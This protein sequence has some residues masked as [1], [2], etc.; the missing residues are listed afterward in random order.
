MICCFRS[1]SRHAI[2]TRVSEPKM[3][4]LYP[5]IMS[6]IASS[7]SYIVFIQ[8]RQG[9]FN[10]YASCNRDAL[11]IFID[12]FCNP[13]QVYTLKNPSSSSSSSLNMLN[14]FFFCIGVFTLFNICL[15]IIIFTLFID[16]INL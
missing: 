10:F 2:Q 13:R 7:S 15:V 8:F 3:I 16:R 9:I 4:S 5:L 12:S 1:S 11:L 14:C 6:L